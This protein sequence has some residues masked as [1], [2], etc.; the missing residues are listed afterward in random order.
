MLI[1]STNWCKIFAAG[2]L[3]LSVSA[4]SAAEVIITEENFED[5]GALT[6]GTTGG[7]STLTVV[8]DPEVGGSR[9][10]VAEVSLSGGG[11][12]GGL[13]SLPPQIPL[14]PLGIVPGTDTYEYTADIYI[15]DTTILSA[16]D[17]IGL[18]MRWVHFDGV[19]E[20]G[21]E[22]PAV[23]TPL[24]D[25]PLNTWIAGVP[26]MA[27]VPDVTVAGTAGLPIDHAHPI[28]TF[29]DV[30]DG[31]RVAGVAGYVDNIRLTAEISDEDPNISVLLDSPF[32]AVQQGG[33]ISGFI[34]VNNTGAANDLI[35]T[36]ADL[37][38]VDITSY[39]L[40]TAIDAANPLIV[41]AG[42]S[43]DIEITFD[44]SGPAGAYSAE[45]ELTSNDATDMEVIINL[46]ALVIVPTGTELII[47]GDFETGDTTGFTNVLA[48]A[49]LDVLSAPGDPVQSGNHSAVYTLAGGAE[50]G[51]V[52]L[53]QPAP[54]AVE[55]VPNQ[56]AITPEMIGQPYR[57]SCWYYRPATDGIADDDLVQMIVRWNGGA[58][59]G[60]FTSLSGAALGT[61]T[62]VEYV[63]E[64][65]VPD[66]WNN[67]ANPPVSEPVTGAFLIFS[68]RDVNADAVGTERVYI[69]NMSFTV[70]VPPPPPVEPDV[71][72]VDIQYTPGADSA[73]VT[74]SSEPG[75]NYILDW[76]EDLIL[77][78]EEDDSAPADANPATTTSWTQTGLSGVKQRY[79]RVTRN[80]LPPAAP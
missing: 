70:D 44:S 32:G 36:A 16:S 33:V 77:W 7:V 50:W 41:E 1:P 45:I 2:L 62:W 54:P 17:T 75:R 57:F 18:R 21:R 63:E 58:D 79:Y 15:P 68:F 35:I 43:E 67:R 60:P 48:A 30:E 61:D 71:R 46:N 23:N 25:F 72:I 64:G 55:G 11:E 80:P 65:T 40:V 12:W 53:N 29:R 51:A 9:G 39:S 28:F 31:G 4:A 76:S 27:T 74:W 56:I 13:E 42:M 22:E 14:L 52:N 19:T 34:T 3:A 66:V 6:W 26:I 49:S 73:T 38:G 59:S 69:D 47:N 5:P 8:A 20:L 24:G 78:N 10:M 37:A